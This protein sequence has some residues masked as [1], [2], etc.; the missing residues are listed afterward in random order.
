M[1][2][3]RTHARTCCVRSRARVRVRSGTHASAPTHARAFR[4]RGPR[5]ARRAGVHWGVGVQREHRRVEHRACRLVV[6]CMRRL[7]GPGGAR[8]QAGRAR[9]VVNTAQ[10]GV[11]GGA[12]DAHARVCAQTCGHAHAWVPTFAGIAARSRDGSS[13]C[14]DIHPHISMHALYIHLGE[15]NADAGPPHTRA[16][17]LRP[18]ARACARAIGQICAGTCTRLPSASTAFSFGSQ[19]FYS[20]S[21]FNA[22]IGAWNT[23]AV[24]NMQ[25]VCTASRPGWRATA[26]GTGWAGHRCGAG[27]CA[28]R[29]RR[30]ARACVRADV[31]ARACAVAHKC[32]YSSR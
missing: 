11:R 18:C 7:S 5:M 3:H 19:A 21:A 6:L 4:R 20:A 31:W 12:A 17:V 13:I 32:R 28:W 8:P 26:G 10:A 24:S 25:S 2:A 15:R 22:N 29:R 14:M 16:N 9:R 27:R 1:R 23:A 30:C